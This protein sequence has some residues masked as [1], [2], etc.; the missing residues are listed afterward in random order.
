MGDLGGEFVVGLA[1]VAEDNPEDH[2]FDDD[3]DADADA[4]QDEEEDADVVALVGDGGRQG[5]LCERVAGD[6]DQREERGG[7]DDQDAGRKSARRTARPSAQ[8]A[9]E[10][11]HPP[12]SPSLP[13]ALSGLLV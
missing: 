3:E 8:S 5:D 9:P 10:S 4:E 13:A 11:L 6:R 1:L 7:R 12:A 2:G